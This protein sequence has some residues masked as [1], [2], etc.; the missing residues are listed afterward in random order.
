MLAMIF[1]VYAIAAAD[2]TTMTITAPLIAK[3]FALTNTQMGYVFSAFALA[4][5]IFAIPAG[6]IVDRLGAKVAILFGLVVWSAGTFVNGFAGMIF[7]AF[8]FLWVSRFVVGAAE[9]VVTPGGASILA[10]WF[11]DRERG[12][13]TSIWNSST[14]ITTAAVSPLMGWICQEYNWQAVF[15]IMGVGGLIAA[16]FWVI[17]YYEPAR[18]TRLSQGE[19]DYMVAGGALA[20]ASAPPGREP[21]DWARKTAEVKFLLSQPSMLVIFFGQYCGNSIAGMLIGWMPIYLTRVHHFS[22]L[23]AGWFMSIGGIAAALAA[24]GGGYVID[25]L[26]RRTGSMALSRKV[27]L[28][29]GYLLASTMVLLSYVTSPTAIAVLLFLLFLGKGWA[30]SGWILVADT[31]PRSLVGTVGGLM[32]AVGAIGSVVTGIMIGVLVDRYQSFDLALLYVGAHG[33]MAVIAFW[34]VFRKM[35]RLQLTFDE[36]GE[37]TV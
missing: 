22:V 19:F 10:T 35:E 34:L 15:W 9:A 16:L 21:I 33:I 29:V 25:F 27:P 12:R 1:I 24:I 20:T 36:S 5:G 26:Y 13:A 8:G 7:S 4:Y 3:E 28:T 17:G 30:N 14:Y 32:N 23:D 31:A 37:A 11:P 2:R 6:A 18:D